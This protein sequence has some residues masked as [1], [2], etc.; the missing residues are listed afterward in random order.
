MEKVSKILNND[1]KISH[2]CGC[3]SLN[4]E[5]M[6]REHCYLH[7]NVKNQNIVEKSSIKKFDNFGRVIK[8]VITTDY[9]YNDLFIEPSVGYMDEKNASNLRM[10]TIIGIILG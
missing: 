6:V 5:M 10:Y 3:V 1:N 8:S 9:Q 7:N 4:E 2:P